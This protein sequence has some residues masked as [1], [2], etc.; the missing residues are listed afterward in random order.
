MTLSSLSLLDKSFVFQYFPSG[1]RA[2]EHSD[3]SQKCACQK[4]PCTK[5]TFFRLGKM[6][7]GLPGNFGFSRRYRYPKAKTS[8]RTNSSGR[9]LVLLIDRMI[10]ERTDFERLSVIS[11]QIPLYAEL[12]DAIP[13]IG[14]VEDKLRRLC[15]ILSLLSRVFYCTSTVNK[16]ILE[17]ISLNIIDGSL[18]KKCRQLV[19]EW[20]E[21]HQNEL[22]EMWDSQKFHTIA[23]LE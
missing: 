2:I 14:F 7:S 13:I 9:V 6:R 11:L 23:P 20:A 8:L 4:H 19:R 5:M 3:E 21:L 16:F 1:S 12:Y 22:I 17:L 18:P 10:F 15:Q